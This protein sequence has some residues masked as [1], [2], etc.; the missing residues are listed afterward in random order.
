MLARQLLRSA[1]LASNGRSTVGR[2]ATV[3]F[4]LI[5]RHKLRQADHIFSI[6]CIKFSSSVYD[7][8]LFLPFSIDDGGIR[9]Y[10]RCRWINCMVLP[11]VRS[12]RICHDTSGRR[13]SK[14]TSSHTSNL[15]HN[16]IRLHAT[17]YPWVHEQWTKTFDHQAY[18]STLTSPNFQSTLTTPQSPARFPSL[19]RSLLLLP[20]PQPRPLPILR[21]LLPHRRRNESHRGRK[22]IRHRTQRP[23]RNRKTPRQT[24]RLY[25]PTLQERRGGPR[26]EQWGSAAGSEFDGEGET[27]WLQLHF[28]LVD[29]VSGGTACGRDGAE[30]IEL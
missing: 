17:K 24:E 25:P 29:G 9:S 4:P 6:A 23:R 1:R 3:S 26:G 30:W 14:A 13:V 15:A 28:Q 22:R 12:G 21:R 10:C 8:S 2:T 19:P 27:W 20:L 5:V 16:D 11:Y 7:R 18:S